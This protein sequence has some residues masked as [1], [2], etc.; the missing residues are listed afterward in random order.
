[1]VLSVCYG[2]DIV[3]KKESHFCL[4]NINNIRQIAVLRSFGELVF[5]MDGLLPYLGIA[6]LI[7]VIIVGLIVLKKNGI[8]FRKIRHKNTLL[9]FSEDKQEV[10]EASTIA[11]LSPTPQRSSYEFS[12]TEGQTYQFT[13]KLFGKN[14]YAYTF[15]IVEIWVMYQ[16]VKFAIEINRLAVGEEPETEENKTVGLRC[17]E[18]T[19][20]D[21]DRWQL[22]LEST[23]EKTARFRVVRL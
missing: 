18:S 19:K 4:F 15:R 6:L 11:E 1:M 8:S 22:T 14:R 16:A 3:L 21:G 23:E 17:G 10:G 2:F 5:K 20:I 7:I 9:L 13:E 12:L